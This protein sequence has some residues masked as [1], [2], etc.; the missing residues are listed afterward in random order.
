M[1]EDEIAEAVVDSLAETYCDCA[2]TL[3]LYP[4]DRGWRCNRCDRICD[5]CAT[6]L[7]EK[8]HLWARLKRP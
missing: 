2:G 7:P 3:P 6:P 5:R 4:T 1:T 8:R